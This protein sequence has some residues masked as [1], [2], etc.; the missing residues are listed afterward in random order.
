MRSYIEQFATP[1]LDNRNA[2]R[3]EVTES[4][5]GS[6]KPKY[7]LGFKFTAKHAIMTI[8]VIGFVYYMVK[9]N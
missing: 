3:I 9:K 6:K 2:V 7:P 4:V 5:D 8:I 1:Q